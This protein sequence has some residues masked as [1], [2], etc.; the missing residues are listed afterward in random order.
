MK[1]YNGQ[2][3]IVIF[4]VSLS[5]VNSA[6]RSTNCYTCLDSKTPYNFCQLTP[7]VGSCCEQGAT[8]VDCSSN[9]NCSYQSNSPFAAASFCLNITAKKCGTTLELTPKSTNQSVSLTAGS[10]MYKFGDACVWT[11]PGNSSDFY[12]GYNISFQTLVS[13]SVNILEG[14]TLNSAIEKNTSISKIGSFLVNAY[15]STYIIAR[16]T[17]NATNTTIKFSY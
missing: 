1:N 5:L 12:T 11:I 17:V 7:Y 8:D 15:N 14:Y 3:A 13:A 2:F 9:Y 6:F 4:I 16:P 10:I